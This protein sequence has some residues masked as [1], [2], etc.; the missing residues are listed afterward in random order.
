MY[1][2]TGKFYLVPFFEN[3]FIRYLQDARQQKG[4]KWR[5]ERFM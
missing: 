1:E 5:K 3:L 2:I 4:E